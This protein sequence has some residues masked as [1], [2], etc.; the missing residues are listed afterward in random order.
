[1]TTTHP[2]HTRSGDPDTSREAG[3]KA[4]DR[5]PIIRDV[6]L[7]LMRDRGPMTHDE[8]IGEYRRRLVL[9]PLTPQA[10]DSGIRTR[11]RELRESGLITEHT[12]E[13]KSLYGN[14][15]KIWIAVEDDDA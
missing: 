1:M 2:T 15:A 4:L 8:L 12:Q 13:G 7:E 10:S 11:C 5:A 14:R 6:V 9:N 3:Q